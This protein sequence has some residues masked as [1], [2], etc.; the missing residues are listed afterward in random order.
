[1]SANSIPIDSVRTGMILEHKNNEHIADAI[2]PYATVGGSRFDYTIVNPDTT[3]MS[4]ETRL[5]RKGEVNE[6][7]FFSDSKTDKVQTHALMAGVPMED[8]KEAKNSKIN[9]IDQMT[10]S[11]FDRVL[12]RREYRVHAM[13]TNPSAFGSNQKTDLTSSK[14][15]ESDSDPIEQISTAQ[16]SALFGGLDQLAIGGDALLALRMNASMIKAFNGTLG[17]KGLVPISFIKEFFGLRAI[18]VSRGVVNIASINESDNFQRIWTKSALLYR[19]TPNP[20]PK[21]DITFGC[22]AR[23]GGRETRTWMDHKRG[24]S[25]AH[26]VKT[27]ERVKEKIISTE[28]AHLFTNIY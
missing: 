19:N 14:W 12:N 16:E 26:M 7:E 3:P 6:V 24:L 9:P 2:L 27:G 1:M 25:G 8:V 5:G 23:F 28:C 17:D 15:T 10:V 22:T 21:G 20:M 18:H 4:P 13:V 11:L